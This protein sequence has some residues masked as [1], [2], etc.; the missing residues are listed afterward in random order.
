MKKGRI[1][2]ED[3][4]KTWKQVLEECQKFRTGCSKRACYCSNYTLAGT[5]KLDYS[6]PKVTVKEEQSNDN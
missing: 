1:F 3:K 5:L 6:K 2:M 4:E